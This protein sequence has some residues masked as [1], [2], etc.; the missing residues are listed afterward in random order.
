MAS[1]SRT[2]SVRW[3]ASVGL[4]ELDVALLQGRA[5]DDLPADADGRG[6]GPGG[7]RRHLDREVAGGLHQAAE[8]PALRELVGGEGAGVVTGDGHLDRRR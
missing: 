2:R 8:P 5:Q 4:V 3:S 1:V 6:L 7:Q